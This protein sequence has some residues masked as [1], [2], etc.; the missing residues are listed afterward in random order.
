[1]RRAGAF[2]LPLVLSLSL[3]LAAVAHQQIYPQK[4]PQWMQELGLT[5]ADICGMA[6]V[7]Q[8]PDDDTKSPGSAPCT[9]C[10]IISGA[11]AVAL[12]LAAMLVRRPVAVLTPNR[13]ENLSPRTA[14]ARHAPIRAPP[15]LRF[16]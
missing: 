11:I 12:V 5:W 14:F 15:V 10:S 2:A 9:L 4:L 8:T 6:G 7:P 1:M 13:R 3:V 16:S